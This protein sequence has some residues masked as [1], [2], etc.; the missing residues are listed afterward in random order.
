MLRFLFLISE[1]EC[2]KIMGSKIRL[3]FPGGVVVMNPSAKAGDSGDPGS[4]PCTRKIHWRRKWQATP[5]FLC[6]KFHG[7]RSLAGYSP[8]G[9]SELDTSEHS[10]TKENYK[11]EKYK[12]KYYLRW[13]GIITFIKT[14][15]SSWDGYSRGRCQR[16]KWEQP[17]QA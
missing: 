1:Y 15:S 9:C 8:S 6:G 5:V 2:N 4:I 16:G 12:P 14:W 13:F 3:G 17:G 11:R 7:Q 10:C